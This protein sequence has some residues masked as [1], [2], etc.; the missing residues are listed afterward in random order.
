MYSLG[1]PGKS[2][3]EPHHLYMPRSWGT[4][5]TEIQHLPK[6]LAAFEEGASIGGARLRTNLIALLYSSRLYFA[7][8]TYVQ[9]CQPYFG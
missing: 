2:E 8:Y 7:R 9:V 3:A 5:H 6:L 1:V 4:P